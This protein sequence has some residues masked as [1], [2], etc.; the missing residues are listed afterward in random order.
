MNILLTLPSL[1]TSCLGLAFL[2]VIHRKQISC[3]DLDD[4]QERVV[5]TLRIIM[6]S[7]G[8]NAITNALTNLSVVNSRS[9]DEPTNQ[10]QFSLHN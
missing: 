8:S 4:V 5:L 1:V 2:L 9:P 10:K 3:S 7:Q 6:Q